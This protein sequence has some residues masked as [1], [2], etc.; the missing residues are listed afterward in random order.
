MLRKKIRLGHLLVTHQL[1]TDAQLQQ[2]LALQQSSGDKLGKILVENGYVSEDSLLNL[3]ADQLQIP[4]INLKNYKFNPEL[5]KLI[6][7]NHARRLRVV[8]LN[9]QVNGILVGM[10]DPSDLLAFDEISRLLKQPIE[11]AVVRETDL[12]NILDRVYRRT[13][14][15][16]GFAEELGEELANNDIDLQRLTVDD[17]RDAPAVKLLQSL[18]E[19][20]L[21]I[22]ASDIH[23][24]PDEQ[25]LRIRQ[26]IDNVLHEQ[27]MREK[28]ITSA[29]VSRLKLM[30]NLDIS[31][32]RLPQDGRFSLKVRNKIID[33]RMST[34]PIQYG[35]SV[36]LR[37]LD[38]SQSVLDL[39]QI[40][41]S[42]GQLAHLKHLLQKPNGMILVTGPTGSGKTTT[43]YSALNYVNSADVK[44][45][46]VEDPVEY[47]L[48]RVNQ[49]QVNSEI[50]LNFA[51]I[52]RAALRQ[53]PDV[54]LIGEMRDEETVEIGLR[55]AMTGHLVLS[56]LHTNDAISA[57]TR[58]LDMGAKGYLVAAALRAVVAQ[59]LVRRVCESC[60][61]PTIPTPAQQILLKRYFPSR[62]LSGFKRGSGCSHCYNTG[63]A[64]RVGIFEILDI[65]KNMISALN[66]GDSIAFRQIIESNTNYKTL[67]QSALELATHGVTT[68]EEAERIGGDL[69]EL[70]FTEPQ[71]NTSTLSFVDN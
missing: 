7:E 44:I 23:I 26:R 34:L 62:A 49:V 32:K 55:A 15:I 68:L 11:T 5:V 51:K 40:G 4:F 3:I 47:R 28:R 57:A 35:E 66:Q 1:I 52:L 20:A 17:V 8:A 38:R 54:V 18:F 71:T 42:T 29:L 12:L 41:M 6:P 27:I 22:R 45:I 50:G 24:E 30:A 13:T 33:V 67:F 56:T 2:A 16:Q 37:L 48:P 65:E 31:E 61:E 46:S 70:L 43:L 10:V 63:Y 9:Q 19:D 58:L 39:E 36:V 60:A 25:V 53:D 69:E 21:Q 14:E 64:G 59:R